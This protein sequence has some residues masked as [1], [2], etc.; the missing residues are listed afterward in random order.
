M[1]ERRAVEL[2]T[3]CYLPLAESEVFSTICSSAGGAWGQALKWNFVV[4]NLTEILH[5]QADL[6]V[7][8]EVCQFSLMA[9]L[10]LL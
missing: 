3:Y 5:Q 1:C 7:L 8:G 2:F 9:A 4:L 6:S 10:V